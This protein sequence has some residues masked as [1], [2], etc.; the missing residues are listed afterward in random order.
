MAATDGWAERHSRP[1]IRTRRTFR[2]APRS[3]GAALRD[4]GLDEAAPDPREDLDDGVVIDAVKDIRSFDV[5]RTDEPASTDLDPLTDCRSPSLALFA[6]SE[7]ASPV[8]IAP[9]HHESVVSPP[10]WLRAARRGRTHKRLTNTF[11]WV[12]TLAISGAI[13]GIAG[14]YLAVSPTTIVSNMQAR[15]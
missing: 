12:M 9:L 7:P 15:Q 13:V 3:L 6:S 11:G 14:H 1:A 8:A 2:K 4:A 5:P 10:P